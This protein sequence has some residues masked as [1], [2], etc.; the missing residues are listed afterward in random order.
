MAIYRPANYLLTFQKTQEFFGNLMVVAAGAGTVFLLLLVLML[1]HC[2][3]G[4]THKKECQLV[5]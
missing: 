2:A 1:F 5:F 3:K 4:K